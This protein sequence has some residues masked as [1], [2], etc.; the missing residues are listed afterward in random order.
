M[1]RILFLMVFIITLSAYGQYMG[2]KAGYNYS[3][4]VGDISQKGSIGK[5]HGFYAGITL[6]VPFS[7]LFSVQTEVQFS[8][9]GSKYI[10]SSTLGTSKLILDYLS[11]PAMAKINIYERISFHTGP[12]LN[13]LLNNYDF[14]FSKGDIVTAVEDKSIHNFDLSLVAGLCYKRAPE[15][16]AIR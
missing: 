1:K 3:N 2:V 16:T 12:Q 4:I 11:L 15:M 9:I 8:H 7:K 13:F 10:H 6:D 14:E 5:G